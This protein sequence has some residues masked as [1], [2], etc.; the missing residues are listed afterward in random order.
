M[1]FL[2][3]FHV[4]KQIPI[5]LCCSKIPRNWQNFGQPSLPYKT[6]AASFQSTYF[7]S[8]TYIGRTSCYINKESRLFFFV[9]K[10][11]TGKVGICSKL[12]QFT[13][14][15]S[16]RSSCISSSRGILRKERKTKTVNGGGV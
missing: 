9:R 13:V 14:V 4:A 15:D 10:R 5:F 6:F 16:S 7:F 8:G 12:P 2:Y 11:N 1:M 3:H